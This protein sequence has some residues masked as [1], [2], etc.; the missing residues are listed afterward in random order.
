MS[1]GSLSTEVQELVRDGKISSANAYALARMTRQDQE[2]ALAALSNG[3]AG[4]QELERL[5]KKKNSSDAPK[6][7]RV[8]C[9]LPECSV[10]LR[11]REPISLDGMIEI[12][13]K[14]IRH[15]RKARK[16]GYDVATFSQVMRVTSQKSP[17]GETLP[18]SNG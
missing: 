2:M 10:L 8:C 14:L 11:G 13:E 17:V 6:Q 4:R 15:I 7:S 16:E 9:E 12:F 5:A 3:T 18:C 1:I